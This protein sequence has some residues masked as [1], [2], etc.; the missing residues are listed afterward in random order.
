[1]N[2]SLTFFDQ[3]YAAFDAIQKEHVPHTMDMARMFVKDEDLAEKLTQ[4]VF[5]EL[6]L[7]KEPLMTEENMMLFIRRKFSERALKYMREYP[8]RIKAAYHEAT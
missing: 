1:M 5:T 2:M 6:F 7:H 8:E 3:P 4:Y